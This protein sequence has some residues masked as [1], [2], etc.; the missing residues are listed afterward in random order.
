MREPFS[1]GRRPADWQLPQGVDRALWDYLHDA[2]IAWDYDEY[3]ADSHLMQIDQEFLA[4]HWTKPGR[5][6]DLGCGSGRVLVEFARRGFEVVG[7]DLSEQMLAVVDAKT[8]ALGLQAGLVRANLC[9]LRG[10][11]DGSFDYAACMFSTLGMVVGQQQRA[12]V[13][14]EVRRILA[15]GGLFGLHLHNLW[16]NLTDP[17]GRRWLAGDRWRWLRGRPDAGDKVMA[18]YRG[19]PNL[20]LHLF[21]LHELHQLFGQAGLELVER[22]ALSPDRSWAK[23]G[24]RLPIPWRAN[25]WLLMYRRSEGA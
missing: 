10:I 21:T 22:S 14:A 17:Q 1:A 13:L 3:F 12:R 4:R 15:P 8:K 19:I 24:G 9:D 23:Q 16:Y 7:V 11:R 25:G 5:L 18:S 6:V 2:S 20:R